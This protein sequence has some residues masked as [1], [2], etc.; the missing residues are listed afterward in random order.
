MHD[1]IPTP[2]PLSM[3]PAD[4]GPLASLLLAIC[5]IALACPPILP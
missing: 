3:E 4:F 2:R 5:L 1:P